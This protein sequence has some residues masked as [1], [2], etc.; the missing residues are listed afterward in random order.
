MINMLTLDGD[1]FAVFI[2]TYL[3]FAQKQ[4]PARVSVLIFLCQL[5][6]ISL[7]FIVT[8]FYFNLK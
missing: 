1:T 3:T 4:N 5:H 7:S 8:V 2:V 6:L